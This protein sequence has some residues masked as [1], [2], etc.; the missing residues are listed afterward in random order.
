MMQR[1]RIA[2]EASYVLAVM[3]VLAF[4]LPFTGD[5]GGRV[6]EMARMQPIQTL[7]AADGP[8]AGAVHETVA[9]AGELG[10]DTTRKA[11]EKVADRAEGVTGWLQDYRDGLKQRWTT[12]DRAADQPENGNVTEETEP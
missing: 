9:Y 5:G 12:D 8:V 6:L 10:A 2:F 11:K 7:F 4:G 3:L 1:P